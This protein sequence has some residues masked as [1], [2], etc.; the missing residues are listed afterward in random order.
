MP[1]EDRPDPAVFMNCLNSDARRDHLSDNEID[2][3][4][5]RWRRLKLLQQL[6]LD[7]QLSGEFEA[8]RSAFV[9]DLSAGARAEILKPGITTS[10]NAATIQEQSLRYGPNFKARFHK[11][12]CLNTIAVASLQFG[13]A[14][15]EVP[16]DGLS[17]G[18]DD[19]LFNAAAELWARSR[20]FVNGRFE[21]LDLSTKADTLEVFDFLYMFL[22]P[23]VVPNFE[24]KMDLSN[25]DHPDYWPHEY[26]YSDEINGVPANKQKWYAFLD[27]CRR[28]FQPSDL[29]E[30]IQH[31]TWA[32]P[33]PHQKGLYLNQLGMF[34]SGESGQIDWE[35]LFERVDIVQGLHE[36]E[37][38]LYLLQGTTRGTEWP[39]WWDRVRLVVGSPFM[40]GFEAKYETELGKLHEQMDSE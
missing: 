4:A 9:S 15:R 20:L 30:L 38:E 33:Y 8:W 34:D 25:L 27:D 24:R 3:I 28:C 18:V 11:S 5:E 12:L 37:D 23:K 2:D 13:K 16:D 14:C 26:G 17:W 19:N 1:A 21:D 10:S 31:R 32:S 36:V 22:L 29:I 40:E 39:C 6:Y 7:T 35:Y